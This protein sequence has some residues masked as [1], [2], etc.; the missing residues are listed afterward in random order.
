MHIKRV[1]EY[2]F[3]HGMH[4]DNPTGKF[5]P[6]QPHIFGRPLTH[7]EMD[8]NMRYMEQTLGGYKIFGSND[9]TTL[10]DADVDKSLVLHR[11]TPADAD[12]ERYTSGGHFVDGELI[13]IPDCCGNGSG[14]GSGQVCNVGVTALQPAQATQGQQDSSITVLVTGLQGSPVFTINGVSVTANSI[15]GN[16]YTF[17][18]YG[19]GTY[20]IVVIDSGVTDYICD[21]SAVV[22]ITETI[23]ICSTFALS[24]QVQAS[25]SDED[26]VL[27][28]LEP[29]GI[30][31]SHTQ[32]LGYGEEDGSAVIEIDGTWTG[33]LT[34]SVR[35]GGVVTSI[36]PQLVAG[37]Q[38]SLSGLGAGVWLI[39]AIDTGVPGGNCFQSWS[40]TITEEENPCDTFAVA[41]SIQDSGSEPDP[42]PC[43]TFGVN[44]T[45]ADSGS[46]GI[47]NLE[48]CQDFTIQLSLLQE[49]G[50]E[51]NGELLL[52]LPSG[53]WGSLSVDYTT[54]DPFDPSTVWTSV[55][56]VILNNDGTYNIRPFSTGTISI[57]VTENNNLCFD[58]ETIDV[59]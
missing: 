34:W 56:D 13:W 11:I 3:E 20:T 41:L 5:Y 19:A 16:Q 18:G 9:D 10:S 45:H 57:R 28:D 22:S 1:E 24:L 54:S 26:P 30:L 2:S 12:Y 52:E 15:N 37:N 39:Y 6:L 42:N 27:C 43:V 32:Q 50:G 49:S 59:P 21:D 40:F 23:D 4:R 51:S 44:T 29:V 46:D 36:I 47:T 55:D 31:V 48:I 7:E 53:S 25:G 17:N 35:R 38:F 8:F 33:P 58:V 14:G